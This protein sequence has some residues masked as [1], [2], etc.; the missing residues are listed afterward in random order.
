MAGSEF[1]P[2]D[3]AAAVQAARP[4]CPYWN[5]GPKGCRKGAKCPLRHSEEIASGVHLAHVTRLMGEDGLSSIVLRPPLTAALVKY[6]A[7]RNL[8]V[9][10]TQ[11]ELWELKTPECEMGRGTSVITFRLVH[12]VEP[13]LQVVGQAKV[14]G[15]V[16]VDGNWHGS[17]GK[18][19]PY[20]VHGTTCVLAL[21]ALGCGFLRGNPGVGKCGEGIYGFAVPDASRSSLNLGWERTVSGG[22]NGGAMF[23]MC[24]EGVPVVKLKGGAVVPKGCLG[25][26]GDQF[27]AG[28]STIAYHSVTFSVDCIVGAVTDTLMAS[29]YGPQLHDA[30]RAVQNYLQDQRNAARSSQATPSSKAPAE[31]IRI[32]NQS[33]V[34]PKVGSLLA[35]RQPL[36]PPP[37]PPPKLL[38]QLPQQQ[39]HHEQPL[40][41]VQQPVQQQQP[42]Q[43][44][45]P[46]ELPQPMQTPHHGDDPSLEALLG[47]STVMDEQRLRRWA[48]VRV[49]ALGS[50]QD[51]AAHPPRD[52]VVNPQ[53]AAEQVQHPETVHT[54]ASPGDVLPAQLSWGAYERWTW[55][56]WTP[57]WEPWGDASS[58]TG[59]SSST[60]PHPTNQRT[61]PYQ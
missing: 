47:A 59:A 37:P 21:Q 32:L 15:G 34:P 7:D 38:Q 6:F 61:G 52:D 33:V 23:C 14:Q 18:A 24:A 19:A 25:N 1:I 17:T 58:W 48:N 12:M 4:K 22:Y 30:L 54:N 31:Y 11:G 49:E 40:R 26:S 60:L 20:L 57:S 8:E 9:P 16:Y 55:Q 42:L 35:A 36:P 39:R 50:A 13:D 29:G 10:L 28:P 41:H 45:P 27:A 5:S 53:H 3:L 46:Q 43:Q 56:S 2:A 51:S 44:E